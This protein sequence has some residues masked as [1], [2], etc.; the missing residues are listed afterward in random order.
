MPRGIYKLY[1]TTDI[2]LML[3]SLLSNKVK[4]KISIDDFRLKTN[5]ATY[6][7]IMFIKKSFC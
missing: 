6:K 1:E 7:T 4:V 5:L 2:T 3:K